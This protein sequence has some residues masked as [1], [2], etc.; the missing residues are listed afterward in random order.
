[1]PLLH[2]RHTCS[3]ANHNALSGFHSK[4]APT[5]FPPDLALE[6]KHNQIDLTIDIENESASGT[7]T[8]SVECNHDAHRTITFDAVNFENLSVE[9]PSGKTLTFSYDGK[10]LKL[11]WED[12]FK[13]GEL[14]KVAISYSV[15]PIAGLYF[16]SPENDYTTSGTWAATDHETERARHWLPC[17]DHLNVRTTLEFNLSANAKFEI[18][19]NGI[20][21]NEVVKG[22][23]KTTSWKLDFP[24]PSYLTCFAIGDFT[25][26]DD[27]EF[28]AIAV[29]YFAE[30]KHKPEDLERSFG[31]TKDMLSW[32]TEKLGIGFP[33][34]K[35]FQFALPDIGGA[36]ENISLV[37]WDDMFVLDEQW[38][39]EWTWLLDQINVHEMA[40][41]YFGDAV[42]CRD[43]AHVWLKESWATYMEMCWLEDT[44]GADE[45]NYDFYRNAQSYFGEADENYKRAIVTRTFDS[46]WDMFD[47]HL[48]PGG[49]CRLHTLRCELG[50]DTFWAG[51]KLYLE[52]NMGKVVE[53]SDFRKAMEEVSG[54]SL[55]QFF[56]QWFHTPEYPNIEA[57][58]NFDSEK[59][60]GVF[61]FTQKQVSEKGEF[62]FNLPIEL[63][64]GEMGN[65]SSE[66]IK[67]D[68]KVQHFR[69][70]MEKE[71]TLVRI[72]PNAK[73]LMKLSFNPGDATLR[74][75]LSAP[76]VIGR[77]YAA[78][79]L[80]KSGG[81]QNIEA[82]HAA[83]EKEPF[84]GVRQQL[85]AALASTKSSNILP[86]LRSLL[87]Q[88]SDPMVMEHNFRKTLNLQDGA[89][90]EILVE[91]CKSPKTGNLALKAAW[92]SLGKMGENAPLSYLIESAQ[93]ERTHGL[94]Q[95]GALLGIA[96]SKQKGA[97]KAL[98]QIGR[99]S[100][101]Y[102]VRKMA[103]KAIGK[104]A[105]F[106]D[107]TQYE[108]AVDYLVQTLNDKDVSVAEDA[109]HALCV[110]KA[111]SAH[112]HV[113]AFK[114][115]L[116]HQFQVSMDR[117]L[118]DMRDPKKNANAKL[119]KQVD[120]LRK[121]LAEL[122]ARLEKLEK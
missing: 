7:V 19:A 47:A 52:N 84:W 91:K 55:V 106:L 85:F 120:D 122:M 69:F 103:M 23:T 15:R 18:L 63:Q 110:A 104:L 65:A 39:T 78:K 83:Y 16:S 118:A 98:A 94:A 53:T 95:Q 14:R 71:P 45:K 86:I 77:I 117:S 38:A 25:V 34:P 43:F 2:G 50:D 79:E 26:F 67:L 90:A 33:F 30:K 109:A 116:P 111:S 32:M 115:R 27:G 68:Q 24:C 70:A 54:R 35:Y 20:K 4:L 96:H 1:M 36:M 12:P 21:T 41:S 97:L 92:E 102:R 119:S 10:K 56:H 66:T 5:H 75:Q 72:D 13:K 62:V 48:Y 9:D 81:I 100:T 17:I 73:V 87:E 8:V 80:L 22:D 31:R 99:E 108:Q 101:Q 61:T 3:C 46:S 44:K 107:E 64:F 59:K 114:A 57:K 40:H 60:E 51:V 49:A 74:T 113:D 42:V 105:A 58:F 76:D 11:T 93:T 6:P 37:S 121:E 29:S 88:E 82:V 89:I 28:N 112:H